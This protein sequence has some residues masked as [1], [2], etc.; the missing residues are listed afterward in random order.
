MKRF[1]HQGQDFKWTDIEAPTKEVFAQLAE[2]FKL[3][4]QSLAATLDPEHLPKCEFIGEICFFILRFYDTDAKPS[5]GSMQALTTKII[6]FVGPDWVLT[7]HRGHI[8]PIEE[9]KEKCRYEPLTRIFL[10]R[11]LCAQVITSFDKPL[12]DLDY[13][14]EAVEGRVFA[15]QRRNILRE[16]YQVKRRAST[17]RK[18]FKFTAD[19]LNKIQSHGDLPIQD[20]ANIKE[21]LDRLMFYA[22][23][24]YE[25]IAGLLNLHLALM[26]QKTNEAS[27]KTNEIMRLLTVVSIFFLPLNFLAGVYGM[28]F[29][30]MPEL[31]TPYGYYI[32][33]GIM[34][35]VAV[36]IMAW[37]LKKGWIKK[38][39]LY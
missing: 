3:P 34:F 32:V 8:A 9:K 5:A 39:D 28:N 35:I 15:V 1:D 37:V 30:N 23:N 21:P 25:E 29:E 11:N 36:A 18:V 14:T 16:G 33:L 19:V 7:I 17:Y 13:K 10:V 31:K 4:L 2:E 26:S 20:V 22:D 38:E 6:F 27:F 12:D 24:I